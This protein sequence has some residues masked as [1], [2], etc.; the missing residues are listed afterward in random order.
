[1]LDLPA[2]V[3]DYIHRLTVDNRSPAYLLVEKDG[4]LSRWGGKLAAYG[5]TNLQ[6]G[7]HVGKQVV[8]LEGLFPLNGVSIFLPCIK[9]EDGLAADVHLIPGDEGDWVLLLDAT[10]E[11]DQRSLIQ[12]KVNDLSLLQEKQSKILNQ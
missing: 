3:L 6:K 9:M 12:Q 4:C 1:M 10:L 5:V 8:F 2:P 11:E 7:E